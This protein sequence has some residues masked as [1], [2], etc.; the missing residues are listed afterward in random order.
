MATAYY[1]KT[2][3]SKS[4]FQKQYKAK[5]PGLLFSKLKHKSASKWGR[6]ELFACRVLIKME[7]PKERTI[8]HRKEMEDFLAG[9]TDPEEHL[10]WSEHALVGQ[11]G[12]SLGQ[13]WAA[14]AMFQGPLSR[15]AGGEGTV[16]G[17][18]PASSLPIKGHS[19]STR[20]R[21]QTQ[22][23]GFVNSTTMKVD[24]SSSGSSESGS[25][26]SL[27]YVDEPS[28]AL[29]AQNE[30]G[31]L[32]FIR[33][34]LRHVI[35]HSSPSSPKVVEVRDVKLGLKAIVQTRNGGVPAK[36]VLVA[37]DDG[38]LCL[39]QNKEGVWVNVAKRV[40]MLEAKNRFQY[41]DDGKPT[42]SDDCL[43]QMTCQ[44]L[45]A[46]LCDK[47]LEDRSVTILHAAQQYACFLKFDISSKYFQ[48]LLLEEEIAFEEWEF[49]QVSSTPWYDLGTKQGRL[50]FAYFI[51]LTIDLAII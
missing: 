41:F 39:R 14:L 3:N 6:E 5:H 51:S 42:I 23:P 27:A 17:Q 19:K 37:V 33:C 7:K 43:A 44:A 45:A 15:S 10:G 25:R 21:P 30:D 32:H 47:S 24:S 18:G 50:H 16:G 2:I 49:V 46:K 34:A 38:G 26:S 31:T 35:H 4:A 36:R 12:H 22:H 20:A 13:L 29:A 1:F 8:D 40:L 9:P 11:Y 28:H 48:Q